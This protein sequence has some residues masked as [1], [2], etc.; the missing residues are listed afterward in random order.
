MPGFDGLMNT[1]YLMSVMGGM[2]GMSGAS[3]FGGALP[4]G[5]SNQG[6]GLSRQMQPLRAMRAMSMASRVYGPQMGRQR[7]ANGQNSL[8]S[9]L[10]GGG[11]GSDYSQFTYDP[12][13]RAAASEFLGQYGLSPLAPEDVKTN[14]VL[15]NSG[16]FGRHGRLSG[17]LE[18]GLFGAAATQG[19]D[20]IGENI[21]GVAR[22]MIEGPQMR[23]NILN[24]QFARPFQAAG[25]LENLQDQVQKRDLQEAQIQYYNERALREPIPHAV[26]PLPSTAGGYITYDNEGNETVKE[27]PFYD[28]KS[29]RTGG[30]AWANATAVRPYFQQMGINN[31]DDATPAQWKKANDMRVR[32]EGLKAGAR[33]AGTDAGHAPERDLKDQQALDKQKQSFLKTA[34]PG[35]WVMHGIDIDDTEAQSKFYDEQIATQQSP[36]PIEGTRVP[37]KTSAPSRSTKPK[38]LVEGVDF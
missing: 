15:P 3:G 29:N 13:A 1:D 16:F 21:S 38:T 19:G 30:S 25:M 2:S 31:P 28:P 18:G 14:A 22:G 10:L 11:G 8:L 26:T 34:K 35:Y 37:P 17:M 24:Q 32:D 27:N 9:G 20:T 5:M 6:G 23:A 12:D 33:A 36:S 4:G 7:M